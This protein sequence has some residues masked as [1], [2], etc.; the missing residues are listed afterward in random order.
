LEG[1]KGRFA[2]FWASGRKLFISALGNNTVEVIE[3]SGRT[4][5]HTITGVPDLQGVVY[6]PETN[7]LFVGSNKGK[8]Y[9]Y[10]YFGKGKRGFDRFYLA[11]PARAEHCAEVWIY[12]VQD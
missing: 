2:H 7:K 11:V 5:K 1:I 4:L 10:G 6:A 8:L 3:V 9:I 12:T